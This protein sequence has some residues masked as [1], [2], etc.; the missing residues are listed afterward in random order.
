VTRALAVALALTAG[1]AL[2]EPQVAV[3]PPAPIGTPPPNAKNVPPHA[4]DG[5]GVSTPPPHLSDLAKLQNMGRGT[6]TWMAKVCVD[7]DGAVA[8]IKVLKTF[9]YADP[10]LGNK[11]HAWRFRPQPEPICTLLRLVFTFGG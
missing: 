9:P 6:V 1:C 2:E 3:T 5:Q 10:D 11:V 7:T 4:L 8:S